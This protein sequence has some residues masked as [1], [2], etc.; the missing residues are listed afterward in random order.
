M[1]RLIQHAVLF[2]LMVHSFVNFNETSL[3]LSDAF[4]L[5][6]LLNIMIISQ[7]FLFKISTNS[8]NITNYFVT[9][10]SNLIR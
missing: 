1:F 7:S 6:V 10:K 8:K 5:S 3:F 9:C 2:D 4:I